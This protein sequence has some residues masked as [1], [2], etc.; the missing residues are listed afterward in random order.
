LIVSADFFTVEVWSRRGLQR[1]MV[2][3]FIELATRRVEIAGIASTANGLD[4][5]DWQK[6]YGCRRWNSCKRYPIHD[7]DPLF[8]REFLSM[9]PETG[10]KS[11]RLS[12][13]MITPSAIM[14]GWPI[15]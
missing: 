14:R 4:E 13:P 9:L 2:L 3:F 10:V 6:S 8:T 1:F 5:P 12:S 15:G 11:V 7:R